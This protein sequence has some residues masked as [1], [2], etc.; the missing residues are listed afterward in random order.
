M[1]NSTQKSFTQRLFSFSLAAVLT[2]GMLGGIN[3][4][5][6]LDTAPAGWASHT[7]S[8]HHG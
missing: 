8:S 7:A 6:L 3:Q 4:L 2:L 5:S 1:F